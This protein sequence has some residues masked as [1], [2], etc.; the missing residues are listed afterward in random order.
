[1]ARWVEITAQ[2][3]DADAK[4]AAAKAEAENDVSAQV[5]QKLS[6]R[7]RTEGRKPGGISQAARELGVPRDQVARAVKIASLAPEAKRLAKKLKAPQA[8][9][10]EAAKSDVEEDQVAVIREPRLFLRAKHLGDLGGVKVHELDAGA[11]TESRC[12][13][14]G[15]VSSVEG[16]AFEHSRGA[17][18]ELAGRHA[19]HV[20]AADDLHLVRSLNND[21]FGGCRGASTSGKNGIFQK[22]HGFLALFPSRSKRP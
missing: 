9:L 1:M 11:V 12:A 6:K 16:H 20:V 7:G 8:V 13:C 18:N 3:Q 19:E 22:F 15:A 14:D 17:G 21:L 5:A 4:E 2:K 10:L